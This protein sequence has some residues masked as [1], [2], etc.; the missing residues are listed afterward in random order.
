MH[1]AIFIFSAANQLWNGVVND[2]IRAITSPAILMGRFSSVRGRNFDDE[3]GFLG[4]QL[5]MPI[6]AHDC[7]ECLPLVMGMWARVRTVHKTGCSI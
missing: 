1:R 3:T 2:A 4:D 5:I 6:E 7:P